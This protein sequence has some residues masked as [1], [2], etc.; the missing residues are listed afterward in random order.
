MESRQPFLGRPSGCGAASAS[1]RFALEPFARRL[2]DA[3][4][5]LRYARVVFRRACEL[6]ERSQR[7]CECDDRR[8]G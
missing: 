8:S 3:R 2:R 4:A 7:L 6:F 1:A 5:V